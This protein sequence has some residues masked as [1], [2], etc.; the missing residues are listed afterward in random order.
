MDDGRWYVHVLQSF[1]ALFGQGA[2]VRD[3]GTT[4]TASHMTHTCSW[5]DKESF[6]EGS[7]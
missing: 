2:V 6:I 5:S 1:E 4:A 7:L 3:G